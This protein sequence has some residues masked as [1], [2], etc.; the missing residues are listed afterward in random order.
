M[1]YYH[2]TDYE[3]GMQIIK[4]GF[5]N[6]NRIWTCSNRSKTYMA[7]A[8]PDDNNLNSV[9]N[10]A[11]L[12]AAH[13]DSKSTE[14]IIFEM[15]ISDDT[16]DNYMYEDMSCPNMEHCWEIDSNTLN[17]LIRNKEITLKAYVL[18]DGYIPMF[19]PLY[20]ATTVAEN[21]YYNNDVTTNKY[22]HLFRRIADGY[23]KWCNEIYPYVSKEMLVPLS[24]TTST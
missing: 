20:I 17:R 23:E 3:S 8:D 14:L 11:Q 7:E 13:N 10:N 22:K 21:D 5:R 24:L 1:N 6:K 18:H 12:T 4:E 9:V 19:R 16:R 15:D 2:G